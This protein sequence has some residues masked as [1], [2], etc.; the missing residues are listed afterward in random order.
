MKLAV[1][2][3]LLL[4]GCT[5][6]GTSSIAAAGGGIAVGAVTA[7]P[8]VAI[9]AGLA[10]RA[11]ADAGLAYYGR[12]RQNGEQNAIAEVAGT[13]PIG[14]TAPWVIHHTIPIGDEQGDLMV[15]RDITTRLAQCREIIFSVQDGA[16]RSLYTT[17]VCRRGDQWKWA[18]AEPAVPRWGYLQ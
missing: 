9:A 12:V 3:L 10:I 7:N 6:A 5:A 2:P 13:L 4:A 17:Q 14:G 18:A 1:L 8:A 15:V 16:D 11:A